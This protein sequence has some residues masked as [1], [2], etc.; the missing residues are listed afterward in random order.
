MGYKV[1]RFSALVKSGFVLSNPLNQDKKII[2][3]NGFM[4]QEQG[5]LDIANHF[6]EKIPG[7]SLPRLRSNPEEGLKDL[8]NIIRKGPYDLVIGFSMG[9]VYALR[10]PSK[11]TVLI[12]P[13]L[14]ISEAMKNKKP[15]WA[16][17]FKKLEDIPIVSKD[18]TGL[19]SDNDKIR[20]VTEPLFIKLFGKSRVVH[21]PG[22]HVPTFQEI[23][24]WILPQIYKEL[25]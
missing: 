16:P 19:F 10:I 25:K 8:Q 5:K 6:K 13:G 21:G 2:F 17:G 11:K 4:A 12:N 3:L 14:G 9:G 22:Q 23:D 7:L 20:P 1:K 18:V 15:E 24:S